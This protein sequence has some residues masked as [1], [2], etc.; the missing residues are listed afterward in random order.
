MARADV[1]RALIQASPS[2]CELASRK[3]RERL[4][5][6]LA[7]GRVG[8]GAIGHVALLDVLGSLANLSGGVLEQRLLLCRIHLP[9]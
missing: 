9:E 6:P 1:A 3:L 2:R 5:N 8:L 7:V 4:G